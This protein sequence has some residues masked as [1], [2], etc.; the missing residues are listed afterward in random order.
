MGVEEKECLEEEVRA[1]ILTEETANFGGRDNNE[2]AVKEYPSEWEQDKRTDTKRN[3]SVERSRQN[4]KKALFVLCLFAMIFSFLLGGAAVY[5][6]Y[7]SYPALYFLKKENKEEINLSRVSRKLG[8]LQNLIK[9]NYLY[10][11]NGEE[12]ENGIY[13]G[14]LNSLLEDDPYAAYFTKEEIEAAERQQ[15]G[16]Y[17]GIGASVSK[18]EEGLKIEYV[19][20]DSPAEKGGLQAGD[21]VLRVDGISVKDLSLEYV[22]QNLVQGLEG[23]SL[24]MVVLRDGEEQSF[25]LT[26]GEVVIPPVESGDA[27]VM[28]KDSSLVEG[29]IGYLSL[30]GFYEEAVTEFISRYEKEIEGQKKA[31][32]ID[33]RGNPGGDVGAATE[34]L[35]YFLPDHL[36]K[37][38]KNTDTSGAIQSK[39]DREFVIG[40]TLMLYT[41]D[42][43]GNGKEWYCSDEHEV[44]IPIVILLNENS[45]SASELFSG[46]MQ[47]YGRATVLGTQS[48]GKGIVQTIRSFVDG[49]AVEF[50]THYYFTPA[51]R[52]IHKKGITP[53]IKVEIAEEDS[54][55][56]QQDRTKDSQLRKAAETLYTN[57]IHG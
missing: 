2:G 6:Y 47:D 33:L 42:K 14:F 11:E 23:S 10:T 17:Q 31:L 22:V 5:I 20:P 37:P 32:I 18:T 35:D 55:S 28:L 53:D 39:T 25:R 45:A 30:R 15:K 41:E 51:A 52:N 46:A 3:F 34:L 16:V 26:R 7:F 24:E 56:Y 50:T 13:K 29:E 9:E 48:F 43:H 21:I 54:A 12:A 8:D 49:S 38:K 4:G 57:F 36:P 27:A 1:T 44:D 40:E 19:Y